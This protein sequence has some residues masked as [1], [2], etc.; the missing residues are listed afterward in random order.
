MYE[1]AMLSHAK[2]PRDTFNTHTIAV[3]SGHVNVLLMLSVLVLNEL[4]SGEWT[5]HA[6]PER[7]MFKMKYSHVALRQTKG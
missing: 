3:I 2:V 7:L 4:D 1:A 5:E 6:E